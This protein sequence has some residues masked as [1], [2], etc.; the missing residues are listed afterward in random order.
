M[1]AGSTTITWSYSSPF[2]RLA[3]TTVTRGDSAVTTSA[4]RAAPRLVAS[5]STS[6]SAA[7][8]ATDPSM[9]SALSTAAL[10]ASPD[11]YGRTVSDP[12]A[13]RIDT[14]GATPLASSG[15]SRLASATISAGTR[16]PVV[17]GTIRASGL[18]RWASVVAQ[19]SVAET[20]VP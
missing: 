4:S 1:A 7:I 6:A 17:S 13:R 8:T 19:L 2:A 11:A 14:A 5:S 15:S 3:G 18:P 9:S 12:A 20:D 16:Y 10:T